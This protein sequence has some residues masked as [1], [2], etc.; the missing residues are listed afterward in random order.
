MSASSPS[1]GAGDLAP[2]QPRVLLIVFNPIV[3]AATGRRLI[4]TLNFNDP[5][6]LVSGYIQDIRECSGGLVNYQI[7]ERVEPNEIPRKADGFQYQVQD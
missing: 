3:D 7:I 6:Q 2:L 4:R 1:F 5:D